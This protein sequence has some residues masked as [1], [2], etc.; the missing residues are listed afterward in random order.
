MNRLASTLIYFVAVGILICYF[1][2]YMLVLALRGREYLLLLWNHQINSKLRSEASPKE[3]EADPKESDTKLIGAIT[4]IG[5]NVQAIES[6]G[7]AKPG[8]LL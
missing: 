7:W 5:K 2:I 8:A 3:P 1:P 4:D 6:L